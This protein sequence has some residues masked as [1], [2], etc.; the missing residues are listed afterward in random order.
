MDKPY[1]FERLPQDGHYIRLLRV[2]PGS[3]DDEISVALSITKM[4]EAAGTYDAI[5]YTW[6]SSDVL[7]QIQ[8]YPGAGYVTVR[9]N[10]WRFLR[11]CRS[12]AI[13]DR[14]NLLWIDSI[15]IN[16]QDLLEKSLQVS[17]MR[18]VFVKGNAS[19]VLIWLDKLSERDTILPDDIALIRQTCQRSSL[20]GVERNRQASSEIFPVTI[21]TT[22]E[23]KATFSRLSSFITTLAHHPYWFRLWVVQEL[24]AAQDQF[25][26][27]AGDLLVEPDVTYVLGHGLWNLYLRQCARSPDP[28]HQLLWTW[29]IL[30][31]MDTSDGPEQNIELELTTALATYELFNCEN[32]RDRIYGLLG[33]LKADLPAATMTVDYSI[34]VWRLFLKGLDYLLDESAMHERP[35]RFAHMRHLMNALEFTSVDVQ[36][37][38]VSARPRAHGN[39]GLVQ[40]FLSEE[41]RSFVT[42]STDLNNAFERCHISS[43]I[44]KPF[45]IVRQSFL[46]RV[47]RGQSNKLIDRSVDADAR[48]LGWRFWV[49]SRGQNWVSWSCQNQSWVCWIGHDFPLALTLRS[50]GML[51]ITGMYSQNQTTKT[52]QIEKMPEHLRW[53]FQK[54]VDCHIQEMKS[55][56]SA[57]T[58]PQISHSL[59][60]V[61]QLIELGYDWESSNRFATSRFLP[62]GFG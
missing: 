61:I 46:E 9:D 54:H 50:N 40:N 20:A 15:C 53:H 33:I 27:I 8:I 57:G 22:P 12:S 39:S 18:Q 51:E 28:D 58:E 34:E 59:L 42:A 37:I 4:S 55:C 7:H 41:F 24:H 19:R 14:V 36:R 56:W 38:D 2:L 47:Y 23:E 21:I 52:W 45:R 35:I 49:W 29:N 62:R 26:I 17:K 60:Q 5:S 32:R 6:G 44:S 13:K 16:Q 3:E 48:R 25:S 30:Q 43:P 11:H 10:I 1:N 31:G